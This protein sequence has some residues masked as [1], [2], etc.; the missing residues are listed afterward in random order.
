MDYT[1]VTIAGWIFAIIAAILIGMG[2]T[3]LSG[4]GTLAIPLM[5]ILYGGKPSTG[6]I[7]PMLCMADIFGV[8]YY[9]RHADWKHIFR[10]LP[11]AMA[12]VIIALLIGNKVSDHTF[13]N[14]I[15]VTVLFSVG[16][17]FWQDFHRDKLE[18]PSKRWY[19]AIFGLAGG[20]STMIG[21]AAGP[22]MAIF[23]QSM[24]LP[25]N[26]YIGTGA[27]FFLIVNYTK[28]PLQMFVWKNITFSSLTFNIILLPAIAL[29][30]YL[31][32]KLVD[33]LPEKAYRIFILIS[34]AVSA[35]FLLF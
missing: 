31:G 6:I 23:L 22:I 5:A 16:L 30:A 9:H 25:K 15:G 27:W 13:K 12:G 35:F 26:S 24:R 19:S 17:M 29:G 34:T 10:L 1:Q 33:L 20:F 32:V 8:L 11:W 7:L 2:K 28:V 21:N 4:A 18:V 3:G 14:I